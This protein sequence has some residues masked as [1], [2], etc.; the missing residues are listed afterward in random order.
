MVEDFPSSLPV[1]QVLE[2]LAFPLTESL[3]VDPSHHNPLLVV[4]VALQRLVV[5][6][7]PDL[8]GRVIGA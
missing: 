4:V 2:E 7:P 5:D 1:P 8:S 3:I 6:L